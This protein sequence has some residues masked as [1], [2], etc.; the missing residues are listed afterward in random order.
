MSIDIILKPQKEEVVTNLN[1]K[2]C[3]LI[4]VKMLVTED[5]EED[6]EIDPFGFDEIDIKVK[7][8]EKGMISR[9]V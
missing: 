3:K 4:V 8:G 7:E 1:D 6:K 5:T 2:D 9:I